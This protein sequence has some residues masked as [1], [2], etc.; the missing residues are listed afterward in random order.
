[1]GTILIIV[2]IL[3]LVGAL[4]TWGHSRNWGYFPSGGLGLV[5]VVLI[6]LVLLGRI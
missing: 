5:V 1:M 6:I 4:P 3:L 2:L